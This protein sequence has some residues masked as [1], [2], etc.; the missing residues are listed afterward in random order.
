MAELID[1]QEDA[2]YCK[3]KRGAAGDVLGAAHPD[4]PPGHGAAA[5][6]PIGGVPG[7]RLGLQTAPRLWH[8]G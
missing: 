7:Q 1:V 5:S 6:R 2:R 4:R 3:G 8:R